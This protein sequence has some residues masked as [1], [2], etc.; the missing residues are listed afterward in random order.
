[1]FVVIASS[2]YG[3]NDDIDWMSTLVFLTAN[4]AWQPVS[5][6]QA[7]FTVLHIYD[8]HLDTVFAVRYVISSR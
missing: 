6:D 2:I 1:M 4:M 7:E 8:S 5:F 3:S